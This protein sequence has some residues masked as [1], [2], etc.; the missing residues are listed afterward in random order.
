MPEAEVFKLAGEPAL[1]L[2]RLAAAGPPV[3]YVHGATF[4]AALSVGYRFADG[5]SWE[6]SLQAAGF[7]VWSFDFAGFGRITAH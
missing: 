5:I 3:L 4:P 1:Q 7:D 2:R 6:D